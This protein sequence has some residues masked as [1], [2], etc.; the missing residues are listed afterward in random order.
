MP[1]VGPHV[2][3]QRRRLEEGER[4]GDGVLPEHRER[5]VHRA[6]GADQLR[7][8]HEELGDVGASM[9]GGR[10]RGGVGEVDDDDPVGAEHDVVRVQQAV[11]DARGVQPLHCAPEVA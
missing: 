2:V 4:L 11:R 1:A 9:V 3:A 8:A 6:L 5:R 10:R 7:E